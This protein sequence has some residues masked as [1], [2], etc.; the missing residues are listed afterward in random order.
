MSINFWPV[1]SCGKAMNAT[2]RQCPQG[3]EISDQERLA[4]D[5]ESRWLD[6]QHERNKAIPGFSDLEKLIGSPITLEQDEDED[7][8]TGLFNASIQLVKNLGPISVT[9]KT[10]DEAIQALYVEIAEE[11]LSLAEEIENDE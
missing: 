4:A 3:P 5:A 1:C 2:C 10:K 9:K 11:L 6:E 7:G 8:F